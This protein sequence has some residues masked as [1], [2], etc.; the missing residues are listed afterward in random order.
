M[1][2]TVSVEIPGF[3]YLHPGYGMSASPVAMERGAA[4]L[5]VRKHLLGESRFGSQAWYSAEAMAIIRHAFRKGRIQIEKYTAKPGPWT[6]S[7]GNREV[8]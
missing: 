5:A 6:Q 8:A 2:I 1:A 4:M 7:F 3:G